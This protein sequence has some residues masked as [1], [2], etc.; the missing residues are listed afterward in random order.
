MNDSFDLLFSFSYKKEIQLN[1]ANNYFNFSFGF[2]NE[3]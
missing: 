2:F 1:T 3:W